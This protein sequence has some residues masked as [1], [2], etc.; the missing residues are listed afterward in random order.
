MRKFRADPITTEVVGYA[1]QSI[2]EEMG[3]TLVR[4]AYSTNIK[5]R[6]DCSCGLFGTHG[7]LIALAE[8]IP[9]HL[10]SMQGLIAALSANNQTVSVEPGDIFIANDPYLGGG[11]HLPD[12]TLTQPVFYKKRLVAFVT[13]IAHWSDVGGQ[14]PGVGTSGASTEIFQEGLRIPLTLLATRRGIREN[15]LNFILSN[16]RNREERLGDL[17]AQLA[18]INLGERR[19]QELFSRYGLLTLST[20]ISELYDYSERLLRKELK[21]IPEGTFFFTD[22]MDDDGVTDSPLPVH[23]SIAV[24]HVP[25]PEIHFDF[26]GTALQAAGGINMVWTALQATVFYAVKALAFS[27]IPTN[28]G[29]QRPIRISAPE[30]CLVNAREPG[31]VGGRTDTCQRVVDAIFGA[32]S[33]AVPDRVLAA[34]NGATTAII[35]GGTSPLSGQDFVCVEALGGGMGARAKKDGMDGVQT[36][37]TNTSNLPIESLEMEYPIRVLRHEL[38]PDSGGPGKFR[39]GLAIRKDFLALEPMLFSSHSDR[40][41]LPPWGLKGGIPGRKGRFILNPGKPNEKTLASKISNFLIKKGE[42]LSVQTAGGGG[43]GSPLERAQGNV[44]RDCVQ[45]KISRK[46]ARKA[47]GVLVDQKGTIN[48]EATSTLRS[49]M[50]QEHLE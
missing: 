25:A 1:L 3:A 19:L 47:Y 29:F 15:I 7:D 35:F 41:K 28:A 39:G 16:M 46:H 40:H 26:T 8:H 45:G 22:A 2:A 13:N 31:A 37:I 10:G 21:A 9:I 4:T 12:I 27:N 11:S 32:L 23:V 38:A 42:V 50:S 34:S 48:R 30:G 6:R 18:S 44:S 36:H 5:E 17:R 49:V 20:C 14:S 43:Y 33:Q 24:S